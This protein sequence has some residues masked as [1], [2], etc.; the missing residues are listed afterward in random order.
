M[1]KVLDTINEETLQ[2]INFYE[3]KVQLL[4]EESNILLSQKESYKK[5]KNNFD[6]FRKTK[7]RELEEAREMIE[8]MKKDNESLTE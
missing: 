7:N 3:R 2:K 8:D 4:K 6:N 5:Y 1:E